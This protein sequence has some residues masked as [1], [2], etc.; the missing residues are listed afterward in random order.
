ME[1]GRENK[2]WRAGNV[3]GG[4]KI[5]DVDVERRNNGEKKRKAKEN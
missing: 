2:G 1:G 4:D 3:K 5:L